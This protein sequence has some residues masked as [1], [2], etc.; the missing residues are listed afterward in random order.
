M[1][2]WDLGI[3]GDLGCR[4][5]KNGSCHLVLVFKKKKK[6]KKQRKSRKEAGLIKIHEAY[7]SSLSRSGL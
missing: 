2:H 5:G 4:S 6:G 7:F 1:R 3:F